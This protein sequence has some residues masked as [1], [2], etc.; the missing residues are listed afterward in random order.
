MCT[1]TDLKATIP[2]EMIRSEKV[3]LFSQSM[4]ELDFSSAQIQ[5]SK[6]FDQILSTLK[7]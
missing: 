2:R 7:R 1:V 5:M 3:F 4:Q 6:R